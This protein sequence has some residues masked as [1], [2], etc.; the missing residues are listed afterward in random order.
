MKDK[1][2]RGVVLN[3]FYEKRGNML[4]VLTTSDFGREFSYSD[5]QRICEQ[6]SEHELIASW[7]PGNTGAGEQVGVG[8][9]SANGV[10]VVEGDESPPLA[11]NFHQDNS[12]NISE[13]KNVQ[14]GSGNYIGAQTGVDEILKVLES[15]AASDA[16]K[17]VAK[18]KLR[19]FLENPTVA[20]VIGSLAGM[21]SS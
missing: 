7:K 13:S 9:I 6:L 16:D 5:L 18:S 1:E 15:S 4:H 10:D 19:Q 14:L 12:I 11:I 3:K 21:L 17:K 2:L 20:A 8:K